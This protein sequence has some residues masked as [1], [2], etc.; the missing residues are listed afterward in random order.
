MLSVVSPPRDAGRAKDCGEKVGKILEEWI[1]CGYQPVGSFI[2]E[3]L[4]RK[5]GHGSVDGLAT[6]APPTKVIRIYPQYSPENKDFESTPSS[7]SFPVPCLSGSDIT[8]PALTTPPAI[9]EK[10]LRIKDHIPLQK[11]FA[12][13]SAQRSGAERRWKKLNSTYFA[14]R[15]AFKNSEYKSHSQLKADFARWFKN[16]LGFREE[17]INDIISSL[18]DHGDSQYPLEK[19]NIL[20]HI[21]SLCNDLSV[22]L[23]ICLAY[24]SLSCWTISGRRNRNIHT[25]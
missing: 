23:I 19:V 7:S 15:G 4:R 18:E 20:F 1:Q 16:S 13:V 21:I 12:H 24:R 3:E 14:Y 5:R 22:K 6:Y 9:S 10:E 2:A 11:R 8:S 17:E 25:N